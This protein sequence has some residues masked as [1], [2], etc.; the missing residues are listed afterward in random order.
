VLKHRWT[1]IA[2]GYFVAVLLADLLTSTHQSFN[3]LFALIPVLL[4]LEQTPRLVTLGSA[5]LLAI[6]G[7]DTFGVDQ[8]TAEGVLIRSVGVA[9]GVGIGAYIASYREHHTSA[10]SQ[11]R[12]AAVAA[13]EAILPIVPPSIGPFRFSCAYRSA[14]DESLIGGDFYKV[15]P[16]DFGVRLIVGDARGKGLGAIAMTSAV[17]G[18]FREWAPETATLK[19][20]VA[21][22]DA[23]VVDKG[24]A[25]DFVTAIVATLDEDMGLEMANCGHPS[26]IHFG[27]GRPKGGVI[28]ERRATPLGLAP[29]PPLSMFTLSPGD[30]LLFF[31]DGLI[32][33][34]DAAGA[35]IEL[36]EALIGTVGS[37]PF[38]EALSGLLSRMD[39]RAEVLK[40][41]VALLLVEFAPY[42]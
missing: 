22:L 39:A 42:I 24:D 1:T 30:R 11:S 9:V 32:E 34:R 28:P 7:T 20:V 37:D 17:L 36:D 41:D 2:G 26:P 15:I 10:L 19:D 16:T 14:A 31:T 21:R 6:T 27:N 29:A 33:C 3:G 38:E 13:Q 12:A 4:A 8:T 40:D 5:P 35:W 23:R 25:G 18:C